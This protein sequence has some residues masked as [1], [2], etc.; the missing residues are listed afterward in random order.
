M[1]V[2]TWSVGEALRRN[3]AYVGAF[4]L[5]LAFG[6]STIAVV[7]L[8]SSARPEVS[9]EKLVPSPSTGLSGKWSGREW[10]PPWVSE[11]EVVARWSSRDGADLYERVQRHS[12]PLSAKWSFLVDEPVVAFEDQR[13]VEVDASSIAKRVSWDDGVILC[14]GPSTRT[15][16]LIRLWARYGQYTVEVSVRYADPVAWTEFLKTVV[17]FDRLIEDHVRSAH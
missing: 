12:R 14:L 9:L 2:T 15:C 10:S 4:V 5:L 16:R 11:D 7:E 17:V 3:L 13:L 1:T 8:E 6:A